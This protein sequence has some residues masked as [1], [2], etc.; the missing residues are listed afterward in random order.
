MAAAAGQSAVH[1]YCIDGAI[2]K[3]IRGKRCYFHKFNTG[4]MG[5]HE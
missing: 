4:S 5:H 2:K 1:S 3:L